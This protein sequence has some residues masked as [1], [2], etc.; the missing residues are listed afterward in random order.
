MSWKSE[1]A[2]CTCPS[3]G[4][5]VLQPGLELVVTVEQLLHALVAEDARELGAHAAVPVDQRPIAVEGRPPLHR[6]NAT[7]RSR[8]G[9]TPGSPSRTRRAIASSRGSPA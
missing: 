1:A 3:R 6:A 8:G 7:P 4:A 2:T 5:F 9:G